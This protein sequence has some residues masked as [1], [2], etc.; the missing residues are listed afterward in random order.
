MGVECLK[1]TLKVIRFEALVYVYLMCNKLRMTSV[2]L[3][4]K[5]GLIYRNKII[6]TCVKHLHFSLTLTNGYW[7]G[8]P[9]YFRLIDFPPVV[10]NR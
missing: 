10:H 1:T 4:V 5:G 9:K 2:Q 3:W 7:I 6:L 8:M